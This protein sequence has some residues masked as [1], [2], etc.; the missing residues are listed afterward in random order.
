MA[1]VNHSHRS[2]RS[3]LPARLG[4]TAIALASA[5]I[6]ALAGVGCRNSST[7]DSRADQPAAAEASA[8]Y[9]F[10][11]VTQQAGISSEY[12]NGEAAKAFSILESLGGGLGVFDFDRDGRLDLWFPGG[13]HIDPAEKSL[14][15]LPSRLFRQGAGGLHFVD[16]SA[17]ARIDVASFFTH[18]CSMA[19]C[20][21]D[22]FTD[23]LVTGYGGLQFFRNLGDGTFAE[24]AQSV[25]LTDTSWS[26]STGFADFD[27]NGSVDL[28]VTHYVNWSWENNPD[29]F[30]SPPKKLQ[31]VCTPTAFK[32]LDD[33]V[34]L[35]DG[36]G[37]FREA[38]SEA[39]LVKAGKGLGVVIADVDLDNDV[40]IY[41]ANDTTE[42][43]LYSNDGKGHFEENGLVSG[44]ALDQHGTP[45]GSMGLAVFDFDA[46]GLPDIWV[47]NYEDETF[48]MYRNHG[49]GNFQCITESTGITA[50]GTLY[51]GFG[52]SA[53]DIELDGDE[54]LVVANGHV[55][56]NT[57]TSTVA[58]HALLLLNDSR[59]HLAKQEL[60]DDSYFSTRHRGRSVVSTD[61]NGDGLCD[62][63]FSNVREPAALLLN[64][65][66]RKG[67]WIALELVGRSTNRDC[68]GARVELTAGG[69]RPML[70]Q[71]VGGG[72][73]LSQ[74]P[75]TLHWGLAGQASAADAVIH[76]PD[77]QVQ[78]LSGLELEK[79]HQIVQP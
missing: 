33:S 27:G 67:K 70:R 17:A 51:V 55:Q 38:T 29:C 60:P 28:Y 12:E 2:Q 24:C 35:S 7:S 1:I 76:W 72:G 8:R 34:Y 21:S 73:Y 44:T 50:I 16:A 6:A 74:A 58:Q 64:A 22:G 45:N 52:T 23:V 39:G 13:G 49:A 19:D 11:D 54:D 53:V 48:N 62:M 15:G 40:D 77:G 4:T 79:T 59:G 20:D 36:E 37:G 14:Q 56:K 46:D 63:V 32:G 57:G 66:E 78:K 61:F 41:V 47:T 31:D 30:S 5:C 68:I 26:S 69:G 43:F 18:G 75:Y 3:P 71:V 65:S 9:A 42:N 10:E 25:G